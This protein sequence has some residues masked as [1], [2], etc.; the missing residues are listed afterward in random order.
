MTMCDCGQPARGPVP[1]SGQVPAHTCKQC[2]E[3]HCLIAQHLKAGG[4]LAPAR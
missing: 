2:S 3:D 4:V 1:A